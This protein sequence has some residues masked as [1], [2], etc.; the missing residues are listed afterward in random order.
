MRKHYYTNSIFVEALSCESTREV[1]NAFL[2]ILHPLVFCPFQLD[3]LYQYQQLHNSFGQGSTLNLETNGKKARPRSCILFDSSNNDKIIEESETNKRWSHIPLNGNFHIFDRLNDSEDYTDSLEHSP[4]I[5]KASPKRSVSGKHQK[6]KKEDEILNTDFRKLKEKWEH[7]G[8][9]DTVTNEQIPLTLP[10]SPTRT[11]VNT[12][13]SKIP[14]PL[15]S[16]IRV[17][18]IISTPQGKP[19]KSPSSIPS[20]KNKI[21]KKSN[22][23]CK[24]SPR[25]TSRLDQENSSIPRNHLTRPSSLPYKTF[26]ANTKDRNITSP[27]RRAASTSIPRPSSAGAPRNIPTK[28]A[29]K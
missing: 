5:S 1:V 25:R 9:D 29:P 12:S 11:Q 27:H 4:M 7:F 26:S 6:S 24:D 23:F 19:A 16:P 20:L 21:I 17:P 8:R 22:T 2:K 14:R 3:L 15:T 28:N 13:K 18:L 10:L